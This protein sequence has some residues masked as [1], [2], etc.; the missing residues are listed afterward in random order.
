M[1][2]QKLGDWLIQSAFTIATKSS[3][4]TA[5]HALTADAKNLRAETYYAKH[6]FAN[7]VADPAKAAEYPKAMYMKMKDVRFVLSGV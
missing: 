3:A 5:A 2:G 4:I 6:G 7:L 1:V